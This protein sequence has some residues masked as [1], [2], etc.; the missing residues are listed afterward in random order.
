MYIDI[1]SSISY[2]KS[3]AVKAFHVAFQLYFLETTFLSF[4]LI[5]QWGW[6]EVH[7]F[8]AQLSAVSFWTHS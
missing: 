7:Q 2:I 8:F 6:R 1:P 3:L 5:S 4:L